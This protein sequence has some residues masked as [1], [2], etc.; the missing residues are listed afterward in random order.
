MAHVPFGIMSVDDIPDLVTDVS[1]TR[2]TVY[3]GFVSFIIL[4]WEHIVTFDDEV[5]CIWK[6]KKSWRT[7][8]VWL[9]LLN[10]YLTPLGFILNLYAYLSPTWTLERCNHFVRFEGSMTVTGLNVAALM[11]FLRVY[12]M[13]PR[14]HLIHAFVLTVFG[15]EFGVN[16]WLLT[17]GV[18]VHH[19]RQVHACT[20]IFD[21]DIVE[22]THIAS[23]SA[24]LPLLYDTI[25]FALTL[26]RTL[27]PVLHKSFDTI[28]RVLLRDG[29]LY[30]SVIF[31]INVVLILMIAFAPPGI[32]N[33]TAQME[34]LL[35]VAM[36]SR[37]TLH[38]KKQRRLAAGEHTETTLDLPSGAHDFNSLFA[39]PRM[40]R[41]TAS[42]KSRNPEVSITVEE[43]VTVTR[44]DDFM[45]DD[46]SQERSRS[47]LG[48]SEP[49]WHELQS[50]GKQ[51]D[52]P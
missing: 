32:Q 33:I 36:M 22:H 23:A 3:I 7:P 18:A 29:L 6:G 14:Q 16:I 21:D 50:V 34:L 17:H 41:M 46:S 52:I 42:D 38:L 10:R 13:Y 8:I 4:I 28:A 20:M 5:E 27:R 26:N 15:V 12:A 19:H 48:T 39:R 1:E 49:E 44:D 25:I 30:Y 9:F 40:N 51:H 31:S 35:T 47:R 37:I 2:V 45:E 43:V 24:W 11:M